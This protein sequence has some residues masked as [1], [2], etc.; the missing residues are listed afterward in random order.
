MILHHAHCVLQHRKPLAGGSFRIHFADRRDAGGLAQPFHALPKRG[1]GDVQRQPEEC[2]ERDHRPGSA[3][4]EREGGRQGRGDQGQQS[5]PGLREHDD[6]DERGGA[7]QPDPAKQAATSRT[8][9]DGEGRPEHQDCE[10]CEIVWVLVR[11]RANGSSEQRVA[12]DVPHEGGARR[13][14]EVAH[15][16]E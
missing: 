12:G 14:Q 2:S 6:D 13:E 3:S 8:S 15:E 4:R 16:H 1:G 5:A 10:G 7:C 9:P 11:N